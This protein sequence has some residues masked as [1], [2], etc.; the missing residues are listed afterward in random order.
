MASVSAARLAR[1]EHRTVG[2]VGE[3]QAGD[4]AKLPACMVLEA[5]PSLFD[6]YS[7]CPPVPFGL[8]KC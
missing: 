1:V 3:R 6:V 8:S 2:L 7:R 5:F 4:G